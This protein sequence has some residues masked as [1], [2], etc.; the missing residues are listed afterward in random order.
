VRPLSIVLAFALSAPSLL[1]AQLAEPQ[2]P[3]DGG[4]RE[5][6]VSILIPSIPNAPFSAIV[7]TEWIRPL[8]DGSSV[9]LRNHRAIARDR[10]GRIFQE[11]RLLVPEDGRHESVVTKIEIS[12]PVSHKLYICV[13]SER[14]CQ[15]EFFNA[16][17]FAAPA[18]SNKSGSNASTNSSSR[19]DLGPQTIFGLETEGTLEEQLIAPGV[20][21]ND[22]PLKLIS[23]YWY[24]PQLGVN[25]ISKRQDPRFG[26]QN[27]V[28]SDIVVGEPDSKHF[29]LP[30]NTRVIDLRD[31]ADR[32]NSHP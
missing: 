31:P 29:L 3:L 8:S 26:T 20:I 27:F 25:L 22:Q 11:R 5:I 28:L 17:A 2:R 24:S 4:T 15:L 1:I 30:S 21:G 6:L 23:E 14:V 7:N 32:T 13:P 18:G 9:T 19:E 16:P 10:A 12:D